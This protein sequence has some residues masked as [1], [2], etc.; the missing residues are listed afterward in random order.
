MKRLKKLGIFAVFVVV[1]LII[2][3]FA[4]DQEKEEVV[5]SEP[6]SAPTVATAGACSVA[7]FPT[8]LRNGL[9]KILDDYPLV[10]GMVIA[11]HDPVQN[12]DV[13]TSVGYTNQER[14]EPLNPDAVFGVGSVH[15]VFKWVLL[16][17]LVDQGKLA[18]SDAINTYVDQPEIPSATIDD[19][20]HHSTGMGDIGS[21]FYSDIW[22][23]YQNGEKNFEYT[24]EDMLNF[25]EADKNGFIKNFR[26][27]SDF[28]YSSYGPRVAGEIAERITGTDGIRLIQTMRDEIGLRDTIIG[29]YERFPKNLTPGY[30]LDDGSSA[31]ELHGSIPELALPVSSGAYGTVFSTG[32]DLVTFINHISNPELGFLSDGIIASRGEKIIQA[33]GLNVG[34]GF[35]QYERL[36]AGDFWAHGGNGIYGHS[37][38]IGYDPET[39]VS[40][41]VLA[42][43]APQYIQ[44]DFGIHIDVMKLLS[45]QF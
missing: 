43:L 35:F 39:G 4:S 26:I 38:M 27:G 20:M 22:K 29:G 10:P 16:E 32:C 13:V 9:Q 31:T 6:T 44:N 17:R 8:E 11:I 45:E 42:N 33:K 40:V 14:T 25:L 15:K 23:R 36:G 37:A 41:A 3:G 24:Y 5:K 7:D 18:F 2:I 21:N 28:H 34:R 12:K 19:L 30:G 1:V